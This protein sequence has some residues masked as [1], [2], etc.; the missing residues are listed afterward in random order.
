MS[1]TTAIEWVYGSG[2]ISALAGAAYGLRLPSCRAHL[3]VSDVHHD[4]LASGRQGLL[5]LAQ[6]VGAQIDDQGSKD[7]LESLN[8]QIQTWIKM[9]SLLLSRLHI[10]FASQIAGDPVLQRFD[11]PTPKKEH[12][13][14][15]YLIL[16]PTHWPEHLVQLFRL[17]FHHWKTLA[18]LSNNVD[19]EKAIESF[20]SEWQ[21][22]AQILYSQ[23]PPGLNVPRFLAAAYD[24]KMPVLWLDQDIIQFGHGRR[25]RRF[26]SS[27]TDATPYIGVAIAKDKARTNRFLR[28]IGCP[29]PRHAEVKN[30]EEA[31]QV[32][33]QIG[34][35]VVVKPADQDRG[36]GARADLRTP[37]DLSAAFDHASTLSQRIIVEK[38]IEGSEFRL[39]VL[40][41]ELFWAHERLPAMVTGDG[42]LSIKALIEAE[43]QR[44]AEN[45]SF[46]TG[47]SPI[48]MSQDDY[49]FLQENGWSIDNTPL[50]GQEIRLHRVPVAA[51][52]GSGRPVFDSVHPDNKYLAERIAQYFRLDIAGIDMIMPDITRSWKEIGGAITEVN[53]MP[54]ISILTNHK[55]AHK[56]I[57]AIMPHGGRVATAVFVSDQTDKNY[58]YDLLVELNKLG[59]NAGLRTLSG[60][61]VGS[62]KIT[63]QRQAFWDD[64]RALQLDPNVDVLLIEIDPDDHLENGLPFDTIDVLIVDNVLPAQMNALLPYAQSYRAISNEVLPDLLRLYPN[65]RREGW[66][67]LS[68][69]DLLLGSFKNMICQNLI[70][71]QNEYDDQVSI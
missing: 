52:G 45:F 6:L 30:L 2:S 5:Y 41:G 28:N 49:H 46:F 20:R 27:I 24:L 4:D 54:Q 21:K 18:G 53:A 71:A 40:H 8:G 58:F 34:W 50:I 63:E 56:L 70:K 64:V 59:L 43:N 11:M 29:V 51:T 62:Q 23:L 48:Q 13:Q 69:S 12:N 32:A 14:I 17:S 38:H 68:S 7:T 66:E 19:R 3:I 26:Q 60:L 55:L 31:L 15:N 35:P 36:L 10:T 47:L 1:Q 25:A 67:A 22:V 33:E 57:Q 39:T 16:W 44:R 9:M 65:I 42:K 61:W 37:E